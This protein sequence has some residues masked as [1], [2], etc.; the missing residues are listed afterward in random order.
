MSEIEYLTLFLLK[1]QNALP[2]L[3]YFSLHRKTKYYIIHLL[4]NLTL[5]IGELI[6]ASLLFIEHDAHVELSKS[7]QARVAFM[8]IPTKTSL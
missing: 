5:L 6:R 3:L 7:L 2:F 8:L 1:F 4:A